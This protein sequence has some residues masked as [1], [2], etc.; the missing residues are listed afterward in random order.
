MMGKPISGVARSAELHSV[1]RVVAS[2]NPTVPELFTARA[3]VIPQAVAVTWED[4]A[5]TYAQLDARVDHLAK[6]LR[7]LGAGPNIPVA[8]CLP[9]SL[10]FVV[11]ALAVMKSG[12]AYL[13]LDP[14]LP[15]ARLHFMLEDAA[16]PILLSRGAMTAMLPV[17]P[18]RMVLVD[19]EDAGH[20][21]DPSDIRWAPPS[22]DHL[23]YVIYTSGSTGQPKGVE[24]SHD[25]LLN[26]VQWHQNAFDVTDVDRATQLAN[27]GFDGAVWELWPYLTSGAA[28]YV[29]PDEARADAESLR[30][31]L[32]AHSITISYLPTPLAERVIALWWPS[33]V[34]LRVLLTGG[35]ALHQYPSPDLPFSVVNNY[36]P[37]EGTVV[38]TSACIRPV[39]RCSA[40]P[41]IGYPIANTE[42]H[43]LDEHLRPVPTGEVGE[44]YLGG[45]GVARGY[46]NRPDLT[47]DAFILN[48]FD[49][50]ANSR[51]Y[52]TGDLGRCRPDGAVE[53]V[54]RV[55]EQVKIRGYRIELG[56]IATVLDFHPAVDMSAVVTRKNRIGDTCLVAYVVPASAGRATPEELRTFLAT[57]L[58][59]YMLPTAFVW[60]G[61]LPTVTNGKIDYSALPGPDSVTTVDVIESDL[62]LTPV[63]ARVSTIVATLLKLD[64]VGVADNFF[65]LGGHSLLGAQ[66]LSRIRETFGVELSLRALF[67]GP[68]IAEIASGV[69]R[70]IVA[71]IEQMSEDE[72]LHR[73]A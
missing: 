39:D 30:D 2:S 20:E 10:D 56:E 45:R 7:H 17:G 12:A 5:L 57:H 73:L 53:F 11:A 27:L 19:A 55:D 16:V 62:L 42:V 24:I 34:A 52:K 40:P 23:A 18:W 26:L 54:G 41:P 32:I 44:L 28:V 14:D 51:L 38:A 66:V 25:S 9:R 68:T 6:R 61:G 22:L 65:L 50:A 31:W 36:G 1:D 64:R 58:P 43:V 35:D 47:R 21:S 67:D 63:Q 59:E 70:Q 13:P 37:T 71:R 3:A 15:V 46:V 8:V 48:P 60:L 33:Q 29:V 49:T 72:V 69:E 4:E